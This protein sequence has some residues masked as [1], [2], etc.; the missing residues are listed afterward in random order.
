MMIALLVF[1]LMQTTM[2][3]PPDTTY[4]R[5]M[6]TGNGDTAVVVYMEFASSPDTIAC[7]LHMS[8]LGRYPSIYW[9]CVEKIRPIEQ[10]MAVIWPSF[11]RTQYANRWSV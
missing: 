4:E 3:F 5:E 8:Y 2:Y 11:Y 10:S 9:N 7:T 6:I 1:V